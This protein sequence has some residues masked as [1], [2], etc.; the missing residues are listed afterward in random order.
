MIDINGTSNTDDIQG[1]SEDRTT[2]RFNGLVWSGL[3]LSR[4]RAA[5]RARLCYLPF[6]SD[7]AFPAP[8]CGAFIG[9]RVLHSKIPRGRG[10]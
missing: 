8:C 7:G 10:L 2:K 5:P 3:V 1:T 6:K 4:F 9:G